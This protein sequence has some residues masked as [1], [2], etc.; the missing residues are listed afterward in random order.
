MALG[1]LLALVVLEAALR[2]LPVSKGLHRS[3]DF[4][5]WPLQY[6]TAHF[7]YDYSIGWSMLNA[8]HGV[9]NNYGHVSPF[10][11]KRRSHP[12]LVIGDSY[13]ESL[14]NDYDE[15][16]QGQLGGLIGAPDTVYGLGVSGTSA[17]GYVGLARLA[18]DEFEPAAA[19]ILMVDG[20]LSE[21]LLPAI[22]SHYLKQRSDG[23]FEL[24]YEQIHGVPLSTRIRSLVGDSSLHRYL[25]VNLQFAPENILNAVRP[26]AGSRPP[27]PDPPSQKQVGRQ[28]QVVDWYLDTLPHSLALPPQ[29]IALLVDAD[30]Y[31]I[32]KPELA[33]VPKDDPA[34]RA[35]LIEEASR[36]GFRVTDLGPIFRSRY[37]KEREKFDHYPID[38]HWNRRGHSIAAQEAFRLLSVGLEGGPAACIPPGR[39]P[40]A[41]DAGPAP[42]HSRDDEAKSSR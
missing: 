29:C 14:M 11:F 7:R 2:F 20:D 1:A 25:Q 17:S 41:R 4:A 3:L 34:A 33:S 15:T 22:G 32:Y 42:V 26:S 9:T 10:D 35:Y 6:T 30:R 23:Q 16:L 27:P 28:K 21:S 40:T 12:I 24:A 38:R 36:R 8:H 39:M 19:V 13:I 18:R 37:A 5:R 31:G